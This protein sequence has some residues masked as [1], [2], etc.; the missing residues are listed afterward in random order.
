MTTR[1][2]GCYWFVNEI[3]K[4]NI[5]YLIFLVVEIEIY[6]ELKFNVTLV[7]DFVIKNVFLFQL[8]IDGCF[9]ISD[10]FFSFFRPMLPFMTNYQFFCKECSQ[11]K[12]D[13]QFFKK[14][15][16]EIRGKMV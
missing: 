10:I 6:P 5:V 14:T 16:S 7:F 11:I 1:P 15:A 3:E 2:S 9:F 4:T 13:E 8:G 12:P